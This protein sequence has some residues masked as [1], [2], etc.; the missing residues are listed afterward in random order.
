MAKTTAANQDWPYSVLVE[1][2]EAVFGRFPTDEE[3]TYFY[4][5]KARRNK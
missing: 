4:K 5:E 2:F 3:V 1:E